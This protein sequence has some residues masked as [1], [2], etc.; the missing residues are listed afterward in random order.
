MWV[1]KAPS[2]RPST[3][4]GSAMWWVEFT[5]SSLYATLTPT[6]SQTERELLLRPGFN[7]QLDL[8]LVADDATAWLEL[9]RERHA[10]VAQ[11]QCQV[12]G[13]AGRHA[14]ARGDDAI[15]RQRYLDFV[16]DTAQRQVA[17]DHETVRVLL[18]DVGAFERDVG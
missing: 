3:V 14:H 12:A 10:E 5:A 4:C 13:E 11:L 6:L 18:L 2:R 1:S 7:L 15:E 9:A 17:S 16:S 8:Q